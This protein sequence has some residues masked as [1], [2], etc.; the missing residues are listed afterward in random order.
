MEYTGRERSKWCAAKLHGGIFQTMTK[1]E[2]KDRK[3]WSLFSPEE[4][5]TTNPDTGLSAALVGEGVGGGSKQMLYDWPGALWEIIVKVAYT[6]DY[7]LQK[8]KS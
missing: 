3:K 6:I 4:I 8:G 7:N 2:I 1:E 5:A